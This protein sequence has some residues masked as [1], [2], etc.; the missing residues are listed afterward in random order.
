MN[1]EQQRAYQSVIENSRWPHFAVSLV[2]EREKLQDKA[3]F[4][5]ENSMAE[6]LKSACMNGMGICWMPETSVRNEIK[7]GVL[8]KVS[9]AKQETRLLVKLHR[10]SEHARADVE[11]FWSFVSAESKRN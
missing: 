6:A 4:R 9:A 3:R 10:T 8:K 5:Y 1:R 11:R 2:L 7:S